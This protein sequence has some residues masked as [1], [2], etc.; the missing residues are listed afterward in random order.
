MEN[1]EAMMYNKK[2]FLPGRQHKILTVKQAKDQAL[3]FPCSAA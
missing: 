2:D 1:V 3:A